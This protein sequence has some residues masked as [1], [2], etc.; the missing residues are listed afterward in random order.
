MMRHVF[1][2]VWNRRR[3][4]LLIGVE[5]FFS[6]LILCA[7]VT[8]G[9]YFAH[10]YRL[11]L[12]FSYAQV[13]DIDINEQKPIEKEVRKELR[14]QI[15]LVLEEFEEIEAAAYVSKVPFGDGFGSRLIY[16]YEGKSIGLKPRSSFVTDELDEV[17]NLELIEG[18]WFNREDEGIRG[19][20][21]VTNREF[22]DA[23]FGAE[24]ALGKE[25]FRSD[26]VFPESKRQGPYRVVGVVADF[27]GDDFSPAAPFLFERCSMNDGYIP[28]HLLIRLRPG[29]RAVFGERLL[30]RVQGIARD[31]SFQVETLSDHRATNLK[32]HLSF[33][34]FGGIVAGLLIAM[35][36]LGMVGVLWQNVAQRT[37]EIGLRRAL[38]GTAGR[39]SAQFLGELLVIATLAVVP[40]TMLIAQLPFYGWL[41]FVP[42]EVYV[43]GIFT[44]ALLI[45][46][47]VIACALYPSWLV[48]RVQPVEALH[49]E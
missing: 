12:G 30:E 2:L 17:L 3:T 8:T 35:V 23:L 5:L 44:A 13:W 34:L 21:V 7:V 40:S 15:L 18:R 16:T 22:R 9:V 26:P 42:G 28:N 31:W 47:L 1:K 20:P 39:I 29:T 33:L 14:M 43:G 6:F 32:L 45:Y 25:I 41:E 38:G 4:N 49:H 24:S 36:G 46:L 19:V 10:T 37:G 11:P 27:R 48:S